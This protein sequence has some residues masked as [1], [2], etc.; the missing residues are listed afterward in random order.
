M[1]NFVKI[2]LKQEYCFKLFIIKKRVIFLTEQQKKYFMEYITC[3][4]RKNNIPT[5]N[6]IFEFAKNKEL[7]VDK[8]MSKFKIVD[9]IDKQGC[10]LDLY[11]LCKEKNFISDK[12]LSKILKISTKKLVELFELGYFSN[13]YCLSLS[14]GFKKI[15]FPI[16]IFEFK[17]LDSIH[18]QIE[19]N[20]NSYILRIQAVT[21]EELQT[22]V[23]FFKDK[24]NI[25][26]INSDTKTNI[27]NFSTTYYYYS[28]I[29]LEIKNTSVK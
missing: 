25:S 6:S 10:L 12:R 26:I 21:L 4:S 15:M 24:D 22:K 1:Y 14:G 11:N 23:S 3:C 19:Y 29:P 9:I 2:S 13:A 8:V 17:N 16:S 5:K 28:Y 7:K 27:E 20:I 18:S